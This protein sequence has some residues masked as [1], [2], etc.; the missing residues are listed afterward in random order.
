VPGVAA[1]VQDRY[2]YVY[3]VANPTLPGQHQVILGRIPLDHL[4][5]PTASL[6]YLANG[7]VWKSGLNQSGAEILMGNAA[8]EFSVRYHLEIS[9]WVLVETD[10]GFPP[11]QIGVLTASRPEGPWSSFRPLYEIPEMRAANA[12][13]IFCY[14]AREHPELSRSSELLSV[15]YVCSSLSFAR[16]ISDMRLYRPRTVLVPL[17]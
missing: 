2:A 15:T 14:E 10:P 4:G 12:R 7:G 9:Q 5:S 6:E 16:Q 3:A 11:T 1:F 17:R 8:P 13:R